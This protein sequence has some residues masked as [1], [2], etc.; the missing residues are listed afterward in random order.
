MTLG[1][2][3]NTPDSESGDSRFDAWRVSQTM[4]G[5]R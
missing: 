3:G 2:I 1:V 5:S 4:V